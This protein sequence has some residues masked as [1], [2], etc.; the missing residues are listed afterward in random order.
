MKIRINGNSIR[1]RLSKSEVERFGKEGRIEE[2]TDF[3]SSKLVYALERKQGIEFMKAAF[4][5]NNIT[6]YVPM[7]LAEEWVSTDKVGLDHNMDTG[8]G[9]HLFL[10]LE[11]DF[12]CIDNS[13]E[14]QSDN[15][16]NPHKTC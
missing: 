3:G 10:L 15:Y 4:T 12:K 1:I 16:E 14:D 8:N 11:K 13:L 5:G 6:M 9:G 7:P 2:S